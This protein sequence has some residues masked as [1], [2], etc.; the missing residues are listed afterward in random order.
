MPISKALES[1]TKSIQRKVKSSRAS[2]RRYSK[3]LRAE[4][5]GCVSQLRAEGVSWAKC[6]D[7]LGLHKMTIYEWNRKRS[8]SS[9][10]LVP[11]KVRHDPQPVPASRLT[12]RTPA[13]HELSGM[14]L[15][16]AAQL[17]RVLG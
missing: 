12:L 8:P 13:G 4:I 3:D 11:V 17:L 14:S 6:A 15:E 9:S 7:S 10:A 1:T 2:G 5:M 16:Q